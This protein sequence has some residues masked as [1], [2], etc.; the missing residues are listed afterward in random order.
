M[1][2]VLIRNLEDALIADYR[3][4]ARRSGRSLEAELRAA[5]ARARPEVRLSV[6]EVKALSARLRAMTPVAV[7]QT[8]STSLVRHDRDTRSA[9]TTPAG[10]RDAAGS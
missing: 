8:D 4:A 6:D 10:A 9:G 5:L 3:A 2:Q 7:A 1:G